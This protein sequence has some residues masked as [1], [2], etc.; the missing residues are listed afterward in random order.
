MAACG[1]HARITDGGYPPGADGHTRYLE[2]IVGLLG[3]PPAPGIG[4][5]VAETLRRHLEHTRQGWVPDST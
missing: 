4:W 5:E 3:H 1:D 2:A